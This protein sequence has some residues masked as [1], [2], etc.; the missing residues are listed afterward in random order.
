MANFMGGNDNAT[1]TAGILNDG[2]TV[3]LFKA[4]VYHARSTD[5]GE[6][7]RCVHEWEQGGREKQS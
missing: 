4:L 5:V 6:S 7:C 2:N 1:E 3:D